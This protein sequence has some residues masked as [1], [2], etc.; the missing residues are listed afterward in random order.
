V[1]L[2]DSYIINSISRFG[3][4]P[5]TFRKTARNSYTAGIYPGS[6]SWVF[7]ALTAHNYAKQPFFN[8]R[9]A[10]VAEI[11]W[12]ACL[13]LIPLYNNLCPSE[14]TKVRSFYS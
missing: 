14:V 3:G 1:V 7:I 10:Q 4:K 9:R 5:G 2:G 6:G 13:G 12:M 8:I 11:T